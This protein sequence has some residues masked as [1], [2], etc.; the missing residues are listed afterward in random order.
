[1][2]VLKRPAGETVST[3]NTDFS[4]NSFDLIL[5]LV[6]LKGYHNHEHVSLSFGVFN[7]DIYLDNT[8]SR[9]GDCFLI[10]WN[11][12]SKALLLIT[13]NLKFYPKTMKRKMI[14]K[15]VSLYS[16]Y[17]NQLFHH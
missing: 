7:R 3:A 6:L 10:C 2:L 14:F 4:F 11:R 17:K 15:M 13:S 16:T 9:I 12:G 8:V 1:M 5:F